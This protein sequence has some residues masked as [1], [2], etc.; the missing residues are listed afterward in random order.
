METESYSRIKPESYALRPSSARDASL[1]SKMDSLARLV[2]ERID[3]P[4]IGSEEHPWRPALRRLWKTRWIVLA[5]ALAGLGVGVGLDSISPKRYRATGVLEMLDR[6]NA[7]I[8]TKTLTPTVQVGAGAEVSWQP[9]VAVL[10]S[11]ALIK[12]TV[13]KLGPEKLA[14]AVAASTKSSHADQLERS[15]A[16]PVSIEDQVE[17]F[18]K[19][20]TVHLERGT[21]LV[22]ISFVS[23]RP[24]LA[25]EAV[26]GL[27]EEYIGFDL[28]R[29]VIDARHTKELLNQQLVDAKHK[30]ET[31][32]SKLE[33]YARSQG[34]VTVGN[35]LAGE[36]RVRLI[37]SA[38]SSAEANRTAAQSRFHG[39]EGQTASEAFDTNLEQ[40][41]ARLTELERESASLSVLYTPSHYRVRQLTAEIKQLKDA[42]AAAQA[43]T[44]LRSKS[45][46]AAA[47]ENQKLL[48]DT[49]KKSLRDLSDEASKAV[50]YNVRKREVE[51]NRG[52]Y[53]SLLQAI[54]ET[55]LTSALEAPSAG[56]L[57]T[58]SIPAYPAFP[59]KGLDPLIGFLAGAVLAVMML[60]FRFFT[61]RKV[62][63]DHLSST[64]AAS[65]I[66]VIPAPVDRWKPK[67]LLASFR[68]QEDYQVGLP[69]QRYHEQDD[70]RT[71]IHSAL[72]SLQ[73]R[74]KGE[75][76]P[77]VIL[78][79]SPDGGEGKSFIASQLAIAVL[80]EGRRVLLLDAALEGPVQHKYF[81]LP[82]LDGWW[83]LL[84]AAKDEVTELFI[85]S[86]ARPSRIRNLYVLPSGNREALSPA[87]KS[88]RRAP[89]FDPA[90][91]PLTTTERF[92][93]ALH[94]LKREYDVIIIDASALASDPTVRLWARVSEAVLLVMRS[95]FSS[96]ESVAEALRLLEQDRIENVATILTSTSDKGSRSKLGS[97]LSPILGSS[98]TEL[99]VRPSHNLLR[100]DDA[101]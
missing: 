52:L 53:D 45:E 2:A 26:N 79:T 64:T 36:E 13:A 31:S 74:S 94:C 22:T 99:T 101:I 77:Q 38:L 80:G 32:E 85:R 87:E 23:V 68:K 72:V 29:R 20:I 95:G 90:T 65:L 30:L 6:P 47:S 44:V 25:A 9:K 59:K 46:L 39:M 97:L 1:E 18:R 10:E 60:L 28:D 34:V 37:E 49:Y 63:P 7:S 93:T 43:R 83:Q 50:E 48:E 75:G 84:S 86:L 15:N 69:Y 100:G 81:G 11:D 16:A 42:I 19:H 62:D 73:I 40:Q 89:V 8:Q 12:R 91:L 96:K 24:D 3:R 78:V 66:S 76:L 33:D 70:L 54:Q 51:S 58:A 35:S 14:L 41:Q 17:L 67:G 4:P 57:E 5:F 55:N 56:V 27:M 21:N 98:Q 61:D 92:S 82:N 88:E 71:A